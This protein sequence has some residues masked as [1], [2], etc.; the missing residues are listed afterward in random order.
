MSSDINSPTPMET[1][2]HLWTSLFAATPACGTGKTAAL[3]AARPCQKL[4]AAYEAPLRGFSGGMPPPAV[5]TLHSMASKTAQHG[6]PAERLGK[7]DAYSRLSAADN[8]LL[9][10]CAGLAAL[11]MLGAQVCLDSGCSIGVLRRNYFG[12]RAWLHVI[13]LALTH[14]VPLRRKCLLRHR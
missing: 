5:Q 10:S 8:D 9:L 12:K 2:R 1:A 6:R 7:L 11:E 14:L 3:D 13:S 4:A